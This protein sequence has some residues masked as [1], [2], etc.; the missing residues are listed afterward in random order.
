VA[1][2]NFA[3]Q[4]EV[5]CQQAHPISLQELVR[6]LQDGG[7]PE[8]AT[9]LTFDDGYTDALFEVKPLLERYGI[10]ATVFVTTG[11]MG[12][13]FWWDELERMVLSTPIF[14]ERQSLIVNG[15]IHEW[16]IGVAQFASNRRTADAREQLARSLYGQLVSM[17]SGERDQ[18]MAQ[19][20]SWTGT[21]SDER[22]KNRALTADEIIELARD[23]LV[24]IGAHTVSHPILTALSVAAQKD[25]IQQSKA[26]LEKL[27]G[28]PVT[29][30]SYPN[31]LAADDT[32]TAVRES[33]FTCAC[34]SYNDVARRG[35]DR[36]DLP[37]F[38]IPNWDGT[39]FSRWLMRWL[40]GP[41]D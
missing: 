39:T 16:S 14:P 29:S 41:R 22:P 4:L 32:R 37:R 2:E 36:F 9:V 34:S 23:N 18:A 20:R 8:R 12:R 24:E 30:F 6:G 28:K 35:S 38:W 21:E 31:G 27:L 19:L 11:Y 5:L 33:G 15:G 7:L 40:Q 25:E 3:E 1:P 17:S 13:E 26:C 10:P